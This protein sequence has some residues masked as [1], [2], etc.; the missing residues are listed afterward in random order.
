MSYM[1]IFMAAFIS[2]FFSGISFF[3][4]GHEHGVRSVENYRRRLKYLENNKPV[5]NK[6][7]RVI[8]ESGKSPL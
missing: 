1:I 5:L 6:N 7:V 8:Y 2:A 4:I 3:W